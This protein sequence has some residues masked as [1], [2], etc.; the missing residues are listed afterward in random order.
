MYK[1]QSEESQM[2]MLVTN[3][4]MCTNVYRLYND[5]TT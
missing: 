1:Y 3:I 4:V 2:E 5:I